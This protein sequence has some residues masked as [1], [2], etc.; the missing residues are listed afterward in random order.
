MASL[1]ELNAYIDHLEA[2]SEEHSGMLRRVPKVQ[3]CG[4]RLP[5]IV[6]AP[7]PPTT[8]HFFK[9]YISVSGRELP[10][11]VQPCDVKL[12]TVRPGATYIEREAIGFQ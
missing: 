1:S 7:V 3:L 11:R 2:P 12:P 6:I 4:S 8:I 10:N 5:H 9:P